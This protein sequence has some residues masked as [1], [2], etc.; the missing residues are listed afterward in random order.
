M[1]SCHL[2]ALVFGV[3]APAATPA[4]AE[5]IEPIDHIERLKAPGASTTVDALATFY[6]PFM[7]TNTADSG[8]GSLR[9]ALLTVSESCGGRNAPPCRIAFEINGPVPAE[10]WFTIRPA[11]P[12][13][14]VTG[15]H[16]A[17]DGATQ[18]ALTGDTNPLG[19]EIFLDGRDVDVGDGLSIFAGTMTVRDLAIG[20]FP[21]S[22]ILAM[23]DY[24]LPANL[25]E[26]PPVIERNY[27][28]TDPTGSRAV[29]NGMRGL[30]GH[31]T[32]VRVRGNVMSGNRRSGIFLQTWS[33]DLRDNRIGVAAGSDAPLPNGASGIFLGDYTTGS[34]VANNVIANN[35]E[36]GVCIGKYGR[37][38]ILGNVVSRNGAGGI[39]LGLDGPTVTE[40]TST[41]RI[42]LARFDAATGDTLIE[43][44]VAPSNA[45]PYPSYRK[46]K[47]V[48]LYANRDVDA[49][50]FAE[51]ESY[52]GSAVADT[53]GHFSLRLH[54]DL[55]GRWID[56]TTLVV[57]DFGDEIYRA[58]S[59]FGPPL[60]VAD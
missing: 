41:P 22:G 47:T 42:N 20:G 9:S 31:L 21:G 53:A 52:L 3:L 34:V 5:R 32:S 55:R 12:L 23:M 51:G 1:L 25:Y 7:V 11:S 46:T 48:F 30:M 8:P 40:E 2:L 54:A 58:S 13:P 60:R 37:M 19:P 49:Q 38:E 6:R 10:G 36:F 26:N 50:G 35:R 57:T 27:L 18:T 44:S 45:Q 43:G 17:I 39:D 56:G 29:P 28:G 14:T 59:E 4:T 24:S 16:I 15:F 33:A